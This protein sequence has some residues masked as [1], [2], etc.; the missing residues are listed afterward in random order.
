MILIPRDQEDGLMSGS[1]ND[2]KSIFSGS[3]RPSQTASST[4]LEWLASSLLSHTGIASW[5]SPRFEVME[6]SN[7]H[8]T[9]RAGLIVL[10]RYDSHSLGR[11]KISVVMVLE[12][13]AAL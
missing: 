7:Y 12:R 11:A 1:D 9:Q 6:A 3:R 5:S 13:N 8:E 4:G 10:R 2:I